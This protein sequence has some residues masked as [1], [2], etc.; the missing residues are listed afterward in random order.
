MKQKLDVVPLDRRTLDPLTSHSL[1]MI[2]S[3]KQENTA[4]KIY[5][6][7]VPLFF[8]R[9]IKHLSSKHHDINEELKLYDSF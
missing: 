2:N 5:F 7:Y 3:Q 4:Q 9:S 6:F 1:L 8:I